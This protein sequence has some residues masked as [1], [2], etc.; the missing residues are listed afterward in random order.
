MN[1][2]AGGLN[3]YNG[4]S[5][6]ADTRYDNYIGKG[7]TQSAGGAGG[8]QYQPSALAGQAGSLGKGGYG[9][10]SADGLGTGGG[11]GG[12]GGLYGGGGSSGL[13]NGIWGAG[14]GSSYISGHSGCTAKSLTFTNTVM[15]DGAGYNWTNQKGS[16]VGVPDITNTSTRTVGYIGNGY[17]RITFV[18]E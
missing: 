12:G 16:Y 18:S 13:S 7:A 9:G 1:S 14:G 2:C 17:A 15:I 11:G 10:Y 5:A 6:Y 3:G 8:T 4:I